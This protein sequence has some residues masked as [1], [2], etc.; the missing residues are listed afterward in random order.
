MVW[1]GYLELISVSQK[2]FETKVW[3]EAKLAGRESYQ[4]SNLTSCLWISHEFNP[5]AISG[6]TLF[7]YS[8]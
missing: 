2:E 6:S 4:N 8:R 7:P 5:N 3:N 1:Y